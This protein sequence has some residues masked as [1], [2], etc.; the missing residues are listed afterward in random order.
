[1]S[2][3]KV[4]MLTSMGPDPECNY[5]DEIEL[6]AKTAERLEQRGLCEVIR[7]TPRSKSKK[8]VSKKAGKE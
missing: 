5:G 3:I 6:D 2:K 1:M 4:R 7:S 8:A